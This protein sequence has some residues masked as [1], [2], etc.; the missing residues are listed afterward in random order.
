MPSVNSHDDPL[1]HRIPSSTI[2][3]VGEISVL[4]ALIMLLAGEPVPGVNESHYLPKAKHLFDST[5]CAGDL[6]FQS[7]DAHG[8]AAGLAGAL[9]LWL[10]LYAVAWVGRLLGWLC[11]AWAWRQLRLAINMNWIVGAA[12]L[13]SWYFA[14]DYG[15]W[16]GE[17]AIGGFEGKSL[18][19]P[20][21]IVAFSQLFRGN[22]PRVW[23][24]LGLAVAWHPLAGGWAGLSFGLAWLF[25]PDLLRRARSQ[26]GWLAAGTALGLIGVIP[27]AIG[28]NSPNQ[29][30]G[31]VASQIHVFYRL[32]H[33]QCPSLF[34]ADRHVAGSI[35][36]ALLIATT[37][38]FVLRVRGRA[39]R[40][41]WTHSPI[42]WLLTIGWIAVL[43]SLA[44]LAIDKGFSRSHPIL[45][46]Q[47]LRFYWFRWSDVMVPLA[48]TLTFWKLSESSA[49]CVSLKNGD[50]TP[51]ISAKPKRSG[52]IRG[53]LS[54]LP[55]QMVSHGSSTPNQHPSKRSVFMQL[56]G[57]CTV[58]VLI[59][60]HTQTNFTRQNPAGDDILLKAPAT[61]K[62]ETDR[63]VDW[64]AT[65]NWIAK[66][67]PIDS[68][69]FTPEHQQ[70]FK[71][72]AG[73]AEVVCWKDVPQD[74]ASVRKWYE[75]LVLCRPPRNAAG[76][77]T[78]WSSEQLLTL[79]RRYGFRWVLVDRGIQEKPLLDFEIMYPVTSQ[80]KSFA[81]FRIP[82][83]L[84]DD[85]KPRASDK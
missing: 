16:A 47:L 7:H 12:A 43:F 59:G 81:V 29:A 28:L 85:S 41:P 78:E 4:F 44:G 53:S 3:A 15:N 49:L 50:K 63:Y 14:I 77:R 21:V 22:W 56:L 20:C 8:L 5:F 35:S 57:G 2:G 67:S 54:T 76:E 32:A 37:V 58:L 82:E 74:N 23:L 13:C 33:H 72:Y 46:S 39:N 61:R 70:T 11:L 36:L 45:T 38:A 68:L 55:E 26:A 51:R 6:F 75:R 62:I 79:A 18:A 17:W 9:S 52:A 69:W 19:Y 60:L 48:W 64:L 27:A 66:N 10:P 25:L 1:S 80:N 42:A 31:L 83:Y 71:W 73:R 30:G 40:Q 84:F 65:C 34:A 24:W